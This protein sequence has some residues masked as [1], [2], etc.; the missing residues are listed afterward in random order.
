MTTVLAILSATVLV[1]GLLIAREIRRRNI[2]RWLGAA[3][4]QPFAS[5]RRDDEV[6]D[7]LLCIADHYEPRWGNASDA[8][9]QSR[10]AAWTEGYAAALGAFRDSDGRSPRH[11][12]F[13][14]IDQYEAEHV[15]AIAE[16]CRQGHGEIEIHLHHDNDTAENLSRTLVEFTEL[17][18]LRHGVLGRWP[19]G[20]I[21]YG[22][23]HGNWALDNSRPDGRWCGVPNELTIL[24]RTGCYGDFTLPSA[25][26]ATQTRTV[27]RI[28]R[29]VGRPNCCKSHNRGVR[30]GSGGD[31]PG[32]MIIQGPLRL[33][34]PRRSRTPRI[35]NGCIQA[36]QVPS[37]ARLEQWLRAGV[38]VPQRPDWR[39][40]KLHT[41]GAVEANRQVLLG[42]SMQMLHRS[43]AERAQG[44]T[45]FRY[46]YVTAREMFNL[47][48]AAEAGWQGTVADALDFEICPPGSGELTTPLPS[49]LGTVR[50]SAE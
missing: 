6:T 22:F 18:A 46:H 16:L 30:V 11:T 39:F 32:L 19:D 3:M 29:A 25:P 43:L 40:V 49:G 14:P 42:P 24:Q 41:H 8:V 7:L 2:H 48:L 44:D 35:E 34:W 31:T 5:R 26:D 13:Y 45:R 47:A 9:A 33:W 10:V 37:M 21:A 38:H 23:V 17:F 4:A 50:I 1:V 27:N 36:G 20:R 28:Y 12:F 15:E